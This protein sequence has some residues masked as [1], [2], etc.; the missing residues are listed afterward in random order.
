MRIPTCNLK[1][2]ICNSG[3]ESWP[4]FGQCGEWRELPLTT[5]H[6]PVAFS[7][8]LHVEWLTLFVEPEPLADFCRHVRQMS[9]GCRRYCFPR[10]G[11]RFLEASD[12]GIGRRQR[13]QVG[14]FLVAGRLTGL[15]GQ[16]YRQF[17]VSR[18]LLRTRGGDPGDAW[19]RGRPFSALPGT[20]PIEL[21]GAV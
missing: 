4:L 16:A 8:R 7:S 18:V 12:F 9:G 19:G 21:P 11:G 13:I 6:S 3:P 2:A 15:F 5:D 20:K 14:A 17:P 1:S 10:R